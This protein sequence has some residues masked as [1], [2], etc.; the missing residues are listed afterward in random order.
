MSS[1]LPRIIA[2]LDE[3]GRGCLA[4]PVV[5]AAVILGPNTCIK[6]LADSKKLS[7][8][9]RLHLANQIR[10]EA[11]AWSIG[12]AEPTEIDRINILQASLLAMKRAYLGLSVKPDWI[13]VDGNRYPPIDAPGETIVGGDAKVAEISAAS[14]L[15]KVARDSEMGLLDAL[16]P[17]Y[18]FVLHK[19]YPTADHLARLRQL[20]ITPMHRR[21][22]APIARLLNR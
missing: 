1:R 2:G 22:F 18:G 10:H 19:A 4:G 13:Q 3:V 11:L 16:Y 7:P 17:G 20:G 14:I 12:R 6:G 8:S 15:A 5:A 9:R 21:T